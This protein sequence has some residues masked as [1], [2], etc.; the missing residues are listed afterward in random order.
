MLTP[1]EVQSFAGPRSGT[2]FEVVSHGSST[3]VAGSGK[4]VAGLRIPLFLPLNLVPSS[5]G[6]AAE[7]FSDADVEFMT[8]ADRER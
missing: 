2:T 7:G 1:S 8:A 3:V 5:T 4:I 6:E